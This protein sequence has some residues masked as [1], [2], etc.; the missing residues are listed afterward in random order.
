[1]VDVLSVVWLI[2]RLHTRGGIGGACDY[3]T[4]VGSWRKLNLLALKGVPSLGVDVGQIVPQVVSSDSVLELQNVRLQRAIV[5]N[6]HRD[7]SRVWSPE[8]LCV[9]VHWGDGS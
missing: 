8:I 1:M 7:S 2:E 4:A 5:A 3:V 9:C 6:F